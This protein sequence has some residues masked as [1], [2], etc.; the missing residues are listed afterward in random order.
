[1]DL[2]A[3]AALCRH[4][5]R[6]ADR[7]PRHDDRLDPR[8]LRLHRIAEAGGLRLGLLR[9]RSVLRPRERS[10]GRSV[11]APMLREE[12]PRDRMCVLSAGK[13]GSCDQLAREGD[14][15]VSQPPL[16][17][18]LRELGLQGRGGG[19]HAALGRGYCGRVP[20]GRQRD[21]ARA[22]PHHERTPQHPSG[23]ARLLRR[24]GRDRG[25][26]DHPGP[27]PNRNPDHHR[28]HRRSITPI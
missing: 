2:P 9:L 14:R 7:A 15:R 19:G 13:P 26:L 16:W 4:P 27:L 18:G 25:V 28:T 5:D 8:G 17:R 11:P 20:G 1:M 21:A 6:P 22:T 23:P 12:N 10:H 24:D 3:R